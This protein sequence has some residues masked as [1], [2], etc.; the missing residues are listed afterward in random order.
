MEMREMKKSEF[1]CDWH[2][3]KRRLRL[4]R[5]ARLGQMKGVVRIRGE[6]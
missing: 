3:W 4:K 2:F 5:G 1:G 6:R